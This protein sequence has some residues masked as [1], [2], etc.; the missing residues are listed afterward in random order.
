MARVAGPSTPARRSAAR[1]G[2]RGG[3]ALP[4]S[5]LASHAALASS[6]RVRAS[7]ASSTPS[8]IP[9]RQPVD[10][11]GGGYASFPNLGC[12]AEGKVRGLYSVTASNASSA[13]ADDLV[14]A[15]VADVDGDSANSSYTANRAEKAEMITSNNVY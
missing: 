9:G 15:G 11:S 10:F 13:A 2:A 6:S 7:Q 14:V 1:G 5:C 8:S 12:V 4:R 3:T